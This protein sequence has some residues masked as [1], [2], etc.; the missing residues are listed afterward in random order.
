VYTLNQYSTG[1]FVSY[2]QKKTIARKKKNEINLMNV[3]FQEN[4]RLKTSMQHL[5]QE[6][7]NKVKETKMQLEAQV[8]SY[9]HVQ[10]QGMILH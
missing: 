9:S 7:E 3:F 6:T 2:P 10:F 1:L 4:L 8:K 5:T